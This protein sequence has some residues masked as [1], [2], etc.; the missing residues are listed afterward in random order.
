REVDARGQPYSRGRLARETGIYFQY[1]HTFWS[2]DHFQI[3]Q[4]VQ[5]QHFSK[6]TSRSLADFIQLTD[7]PQ[8]IKDNILLL[9][10]F[11]K[12]VRNPLAHLIKPFDEEELHRTTGF[13]SQTFL[14]KIIQLAVFSGIHYDNDKF[15]FDKVNELIKRIYQN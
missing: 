8:A 4:P 1:A 12:S 9:R 10:D 3:H 2:L 7:L 13:S 15:Y 6:I 14:E 11:E 5:P